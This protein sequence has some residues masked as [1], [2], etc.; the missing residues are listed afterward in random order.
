MFLRMVDV[1]LI[2]KHSHQKLKLFVIEINIDL[3]ATIVEVKIHIYMAHFY[4]FWIEHSQV[5]LSHGPLLLQ[6]NQ[7]RWGNDDP[8]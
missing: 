4:P 3:E 7:N 2:F 1:Y 6:R 5:L 8:R